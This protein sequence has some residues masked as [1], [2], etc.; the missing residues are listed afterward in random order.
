MT[1]QGRNRIAGIVFFIFGLILNPWVT[2]NLVAILLE[3]FNP[4]LIH[5]PEILMIYWDMIDPILWGPI[6]LCWIIAVSIFFSKKSMRESPWLR[7]LINLTLFFFL[8]WL[9]LNSNY[10]YTGRLQWLRVLEIVVLLWFLLRAFYLGVV[11][12]EKMAGWVK[13]LGMS[14]F[15]LMVLFFLLETVFLFIGQSHKNN[16]TL[17]SKVWFARH[18]EYNDFGYRD[19]EMREKMDSEQKRIL[20]IGDSFVSGHGIKD[21]ADRFGDIV[22]EGLEEAVVLNMGSNGAEPFDE[23]YQLENWEGNGEELMIYVWFVNDIH[24][25]GRFNGKTWFNYQNPMTD[26]VMEAVEV[27]PPPVSFVNGSYFINYI[28]WMFPHTQDDVSYR[29]FLETSFTDKEVWYYHQFSISQLLG[30]GENRG[31]NVAV[32]LFPFMEDVEGSEFAL[33]PMRKYMEASNVP[34][35]DVAPLLKEYSPEELMVNKYDPHPNERVQKIVA[36]ALLEFIDSE[37]L[38]TQKQDDLFGNKTHY[39][40]S[41]FINSE[42]GLFSDDDITIDSGN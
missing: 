6:S 33:E 8:G 11:K 4:G 32:V 10:A 24:E 41:G 18:W 37:E 34:Y 15:G 36:E 38:L 5:K 13:K 28:Y 9:Y 42:N 26:G 29:E 21:P 23:L 40:P 35:L 3:I 20:L 31:T 22:D 19:G 1:T 12:Q 7:P 30:W 17:S 14:I 16:H 2:G 25:A 27:R 39:E